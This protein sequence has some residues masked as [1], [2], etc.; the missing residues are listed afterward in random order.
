MLFEVRTGIGGFRCALGLR[1]ARIMSCTLSIGGGGGRGDVV[2]ETSHI[3]L[4][5]WTTQHA[6]FIPTQPPPRPAY[7]IGGKTINYAWLKTRVILKQD[8]NFKKN[9]F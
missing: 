5:C 9:F 8:Q 1:H 6:V 4:K 2:V 7:H 3:E